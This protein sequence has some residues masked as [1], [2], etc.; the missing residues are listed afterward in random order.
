MRMYS[1]FADAQSATPRLIIGSTVHPDVTHLDNLTIL[2]CDPTVFVKVEHSNTEFLWLDTSTNNLYIIISESEICPPGLKTRLAAHRGEPFHFIIILCPEVL[3]QTPGKFKM[4]ASIRG[5]ELTNT[6]PYADP[7]LDMSTW[8][9]MHIDQLRERTLSVYLGRMI[10]YI[11][12]QKYSQ[13]IASESC[14]TFPRYS[15]IVPLLTFPESTPCRNIETSAKRRPCLG[16]ERCGISIPSPFSSL[17]SRP[18]DEV[19][20]IVRTKRS[21]IADTAVGKA[22]ASITTNCV[23]LMTTP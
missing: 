10:I 17:V 5:D 13:N 21:R 7:S 11:Q 1:T 15:I 23:T 12:A 9:G 19:E 4:F 2:N 3:T 20:S 18:D 16:Q 22:R 6:R 8:V 14:L